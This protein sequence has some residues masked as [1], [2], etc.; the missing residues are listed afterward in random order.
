L[1][2]IPLQQRQVRRNELVPGVDVGRLQDGA[3]LFERHLEI[4]EPSDDLCRGYLLGAVPAVTRVRIDFRRDQQSEPVVVPQ[5]LDAEV[6]GP[7]EVTDGQGRRHAPSLD[8]PPW[9][10]S[11]TGRRLDSPQGGRRTVVVSRDTREE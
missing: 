10:E 4:A 6:G 8:S 9:G 3:N 1:E 11:R 2:K 5:G 7:R